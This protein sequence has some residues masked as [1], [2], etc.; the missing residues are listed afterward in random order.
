[1]PA[2]AAPRP[3]GSM[4]N[5]PSRLPAPKA[6]K[7][8]SPPTSTPKSARAAHNAS[9]S[10]P[11]ARTLNPSPMASGRPANSSKLPS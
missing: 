9:P 10:R 6:K 2:S 7:G 8:T 3:P 4:L 1:M 11:H 5:A